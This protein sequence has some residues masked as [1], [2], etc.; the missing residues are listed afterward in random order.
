ML[1]GFPAQQRV[2]D[3]RGG[4][5]YTICAGDCWKA[6]MQDLKSIE[7]TTTGMSDAQA[8]SG[9]T[10]DV[11]NEQMMPALGG[12]TGMDKDQLYK[13][14]TELGAGNIAEDYAA[15]TAVRN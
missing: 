3:P 6:S 15:L 10:E 9:M 8:R 14:Y 11:F 1:T 13:A 4:P 2:R 12:G 5:D 7:S